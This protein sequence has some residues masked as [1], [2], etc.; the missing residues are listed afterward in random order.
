MQVNECVH[1]CVH[2]CMFTSLIDIISVQLDYS[3]LPRQEITPKRLNGQ[4]L[5][6]SEQAR[7]TNYKSSII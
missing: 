2:E 4:N 5:V 3:S 6:L 7:I 1:D